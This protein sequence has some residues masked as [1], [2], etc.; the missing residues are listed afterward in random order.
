MKYYEF[1]NKKN[2]ACF[3]VVARNTR[4]ACKSY[5]YKPQDCHCVYSCRVEEE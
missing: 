1:R 4:E 2:G 3:Q 5:G